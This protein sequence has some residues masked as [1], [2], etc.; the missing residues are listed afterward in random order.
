M[1]VYKHAKGKVCTE[2]KEEII[3]N[4]ALWSLNK[5]SSEEIA[6]YIFN[7]YPKDEEVKLVLTLLSK[8]DLQRTTKIKGHLEKLRKLEA[9][10]FLKT[11]NS[12]NKEK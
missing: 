11:I 1:S 3:N 12:W 2:K 8:V 6:I 10:A 9:D 7:N 4:V 5:D